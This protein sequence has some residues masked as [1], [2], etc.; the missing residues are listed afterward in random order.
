MEKTIEG[1]LEWRRH[2]PSYKLPVE[3]VK[4]IDWLVGEVVRYLKDQERYSC[5]TCPQKCEGH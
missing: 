3:D 4:A 5:E 2:L 1:I